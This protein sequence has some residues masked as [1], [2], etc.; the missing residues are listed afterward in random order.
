MIRMH[1][2]NY[3]WDHRHTILWMGKKLFLYI[4]VSENLIWK[5]AHC[6]FINKRS[7]E[8]IVFIFLNVLHLFI[9][10]KN[11]TTSFLERLV[12]QLMELFKSRG[13]PS[14][15]KWQTCGQTV[16]SLPAWNTLYFIFAI[17]KHFN[18]MATRQ[19]FCLLFFRVKMTMIVLLLVISNDLKY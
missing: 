1:T 8:N 2:E 7:T 18:V 4:F 15:R 12:Y 19:V 11:P 5:A 13:H 9:L 3:P 6:T 10:Q 17:I 16:L 14:Y